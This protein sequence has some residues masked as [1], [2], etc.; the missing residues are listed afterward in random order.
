MPTHFPLN[1]HLLS[2]PAEAL[3]C[4]A[5]YVV[6]AL[7]PSQ[8]GDAEACERNFDRRLEVTAKI[9]AELVERGVEPE[10]ANMAAGSFMTFGFAPDFGL[11]PT[12]HS[13]P[14][15]ASKA[16]AALTDWTNAKAEAWNRQVA[17]IARRAA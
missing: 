13:K 5:E 11:S 1:A 12:A 6:P 17:K 4:F 7:E 15:L 10:I 8:W 9:A 2:Q 16:L 14:W 3:A